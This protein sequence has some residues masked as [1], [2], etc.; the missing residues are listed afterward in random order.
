MKVLLIGDYPPPHGGV[1]VHVHQ[2]YQFLRARGVQV[3]VLDIGK[4]GRPDPD[5]LPARSLPLFAARIAQFSVAGWRLH[6]HTSG[7]NPKSWAVAAAVGLL[8]SPLAPA[9]VLTLH[10][11]LLPA[12]LRGS[13]AHR[14]LAR[15]AMLGYGRVVA[16]SEPI[17][18][19]LVEVGVPAAKV[20]VLPAFLS[21]QVKPGVPPAGFEQIRQRRPTLVAMA[22]HPSPVYGRALMFEALAL[23]AKR[24]PGMALALF[25]PGTR[26]AELLQEARRAGVEDRIEDFGELPHPQALGLIAGCDAFIRPTTADGDSVS[27]REALALGVPCVASDVVARPMGTLCFRAGD[28]RHLAEILLRAVRERPAPICGP[29]AGPALLQLYQTLAGTPAAAPF[30]AHTT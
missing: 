4:G 14:V 5:V 19:A 15:A 12:F 29:D 3:R 24:A 1:A 9:P 23:A 6:L 17:R 10:S 27:V 11:G 28:P 22:H 26:S 7:N 2:L 21:S 16:V 25:G 18:E 30:S 13:P 8:R 20:V